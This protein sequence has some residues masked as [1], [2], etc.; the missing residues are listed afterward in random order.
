M[1]MLRLHASQFGFFWS[2]FFRRTLPDAGPGISWVLGNGKRQAVLDLE[3][4]GRT[5]LLPASHTSTVSC[6]PRPGFHLRHDL[7]PV[8]AVLSVRLCRLVC[9]VYLYSTAC[10]SFPNVK[11]WLSAP[12]DAHSKIRREYSPRQ[13]TLGRKLSVPQ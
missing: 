8:K 4:S 1:R 11:N 13:D 9:R 7:I 5:I 3:R 10:R 2:H 12:P 6:S